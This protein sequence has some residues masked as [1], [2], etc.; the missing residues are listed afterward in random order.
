V[1]DGSVRSVLDGSV[2]S[3]VGRKC[4]EWCWMEL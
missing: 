2:K 3:G 1:L 4:A